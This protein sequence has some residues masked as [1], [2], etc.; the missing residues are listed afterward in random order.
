VS[1]RFGVVGS[2]VLCAASSAQAYC[3]TH[4]LD[5][6]VSSCPSFCT[7]IGLPLAWTESEIPYAFNQRGFPGLSDAQLRATFAAAFA[8]WSQVT[9]GGLST[10]LTFTPEPLPTVLDDGPLELEPNTNVILHYD[11]QTWLA[12]DHSPHAFAVT[13]V[14]FSKNGDL[15]GADIMFNGAMGPFGDCTSTPCGPEL[16][17]RADLQNVATHEVGHL[18]GLA[19]SDADGSTMACEASAGETLKRSLEA[20]DVDGLCSAYP[21]GVAFPERAPDDGC[22]LAGTRGG[23]WLLALLVFLLRQRVTPSTRKP[24]ARSHS[25]TLAG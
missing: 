12:Q 2:I 16:A 15:F 5:A 3:R 20:D 17:V 1:W 8:T 9:C 14:W 4:S 24:S 21:P 7:N 22:S 19:H 11:A 6:D 13:S 25:A 23:A 10:G 18:L